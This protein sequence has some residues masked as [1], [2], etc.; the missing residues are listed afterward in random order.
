[1]RTR[2]V[3][4]EAEGDG[5]EAASRLGGSGPARRFR[6]LSQRLRSETAELH[7]QAEIALG[8]PG[9]IQDRASYAATLER[10][11]GLYE[12]LEQALSRHRGWSRLGLNLHERSHSSRLARD[13]AAIGAWP[14]RKLASSVAWLTSFPQALGVIYVLEGSTLGGQII[15]R[16]L[17]AMAIEIPAEATAFFSGHGA[18]TGAMW[19]SFVEALDIFGERHPEACDSVQEGATLTFQAVIARFTHPL[20]PSEAS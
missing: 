13:L 10:F 7:R 15:L 5:S 4:L 18:R 3:H 8:F 2:P 6:P 20:Q 14:C 16:R 1:M 11:Y 17:E 9:C 19:R 12:P